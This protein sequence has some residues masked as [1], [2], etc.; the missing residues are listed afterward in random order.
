MLPLMLHYVGFLKNL[1]H[2]FHLSIHKDTHTQY[3]R[4]GTASHHTHAH[5]CIDVLYFLFSFYWVVSP[6][7]TWHASP[8]TVTR[9]YSSL[10][11]NLAIFF[12]ESAMPSNGCFTPSPSWRGIYKPHVLY[13]LLMILKGS[14]HIGTHGASVTVSMVDASRQCSSFCFLHTRLFKTRLSKNL[15]DY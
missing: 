13:V 1:S 5:V 4:Q 2:H 14:L 7:V 3:T 15:L 6:H 12:N 11:Q 8:L 10:D 9:D